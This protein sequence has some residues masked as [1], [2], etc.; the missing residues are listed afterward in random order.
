MEKPTKPTPM[1]EIMG[2]ALNK[3]ADGYAKAW[4]EDIGDA[5]GNTLL[6]AFITLGMGFFLALCL[7]LI[8]IASLIAFLVIWFG[9]GMVRQW[10][11]H[12][13][14]ARWESGNEED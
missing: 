5:V 2:G 7:T 9:L 3:L 10:A 4:N 14:M 1:L 6:F 13:M 11:Y 12:R 8:P